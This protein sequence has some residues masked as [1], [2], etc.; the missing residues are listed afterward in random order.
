MGGDDGDEENVEGLVS[1]QELMEH[2]SSVLGSDEDSVYRLPENFKRVKQ[3][4]EQEVAR[5]K[6]NQKVSFDDLLEPGAGDYCQL[7][8]GMTPSAVKNLWSHCKEAFANC[9]FHTNPSRRRKKARHRRISSV[10][11]YGSAMLE[12]EGIPPNDKEEEHEEARAVVPPK[13]KEEAIAFEDE[14]ENGGDSEHDV[15]EYEE[16][17]YEDCDGVG[18][19]RNACTPPFKRGRGRLPV[20]RPQ[21]RFYLVLRGMRTGVT[22]Q[23]LAEWFGLKSKN[24][25]VRYLFSG[26]QAFRTSMIGDFLVIPTAES[27]LHRTPHEWKM[28]FG[29]SVVLTADGTHFELD[30]PEDGLLSWATYCSYKGYNSQQTL[31]LVDPSQLIVG[32]T[33]F[34]PGRSHELSHVWEAT[35]MGNVLQ[36]YG[37]QRV[38]LLAD[39]AYVSLKDHGNVTVRTPAKSK[40]QFT[41]DQQNQTRALARYRV[42]VEHVVGKLKLWKG[43]CSGAAMRFYDI[44]E[45]EGG[46]GESLLGTRDDRLFLAAALWNASR[47]NGKPLPRNLGS[48][49]CAAPRLQVH[50]SLEKSSKVPM[51][52]RSRFRALP[53]QTWAD[54]SR[55]FSLDLNTH[56]NLLAKGWKSVLGG[57]VCGLRFCDE[58]RNAVHT[59]LGAV[60]LPSMKQGVYY[61]GLRFDGQQLVGSYCTCQ[62]GGSNAEGLTL[63]RHVLSTCIVIGLMQNA[64]HEDAQTGKW[65]K[66]AVMKKRTDLNI[67]LV[68]SDR[69]LWPPRCECLKMGLEDVQ[70]CAKAARGIVA[71]H[72]ALLAGGWD[73]LRTTVEAERARLDRAKQTLASLPFYELSQRKRG[74][75]VLLC[76]E[77]NIVVPIRATKE[78]MAWLYIKKKLDTNDDPEGVYASERQRLT[79]QQCRTLYFA[80]DGGDRWVRCSRRGCFQWN[81]LGCEGLANEAAK[82]QKKYCCKK[83]SGEGG[84]EDAEDV[85]IA[86]DLFFEGDSNG[87]P[88]PAADSTLSGHHVS[89]GMRGGRLVQLGSLVFPEDEVGAH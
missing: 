63:C 59:S 4:L 22:L 60:V 5:L 69:C 40:K 50:A 33:S 49:V 85:P 86:K 76:H 29:E 79:C 23:L 12:E 81:H 25:A 62:A 31:L 17:E 39:K 56:C 52:V 67:C 8:T 55:V 27:V 80:D 58:G 11:A 65:F 83:C 26:M 54:L 19:D 16:E 48:A 14:E 77:E 3:Q 21:D 28:A 20:L 10:P 87:P 24:S 37:R 15:E 71:V 30:V 6:R 57:S 75:L 44:K 70:A 32:I 74:D 73:S 34:M 51:A 13:D 18:E 64:L 45:N 84:K 41:F 47:L 61:M 53:I 7:M 38:T 82:R 72:P 88:N 2:A 66:Q 9:K 35:G 78:E 36:A 1:E 42:Y 43:L 46:M 68:H 89:D